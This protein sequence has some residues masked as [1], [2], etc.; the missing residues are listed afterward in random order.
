GGK[1][2][3]LLAVAITN[4]SPDRS[5]IQESTAPRASE[6]TP[7]SAPPPV[8]PCNAFS[9]SSNQT[10]QRP[11]ASM[12]RKAFRKLPSDSPTN[13]DFSA[14]RST[15]NSGTPH[16]VAMAFAVKDLPQPGT[17]TSNAPFGA[18]KPY[19]RAAGL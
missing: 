6:E 5:C 2:S 13:F 1:V 18:G 3:T 7:P 19:A 4:A 12:T 15:R 11:I 14:P 10:T 17:P 16:A 9:I 8:A